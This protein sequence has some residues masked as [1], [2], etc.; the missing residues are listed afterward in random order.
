MTES[1]ALVFEY[2]CAEKIVCRTEERCRKGDADVTKVK[3]GLSKIMWRRMLCV[4]L[5][6]VTV[7]GGVTGVRLFQIMV[8]HGEEYQS[9]ASEQQLYDTTLTAP[10]GNIYDAKMNVLATSRT[11]W[12]TLLRRWSR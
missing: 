10:R 2:Y 6:L 1:S 11:C 7:I 3:K 9:K 4:M 8:V 5:A 12:T